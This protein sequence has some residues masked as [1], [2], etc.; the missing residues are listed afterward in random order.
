MPDERSITEKAQDR[1]NERSLKASADSAKAT[2]RSVEQMLRLSK[3]QLGASKAQ[4]ELTR[5]AR[6]DAEKSERFTRT[7]AW[8]SLA[9][10]IASLGAALAALFVR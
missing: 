10:A 4:V 7:M 1:R 2:A 9:V 3:D 6:A 8:S 5:A